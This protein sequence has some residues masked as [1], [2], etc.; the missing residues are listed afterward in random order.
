MAIDMT[1]WSPVMRRILFNGSTVSPLPGRI[2]P[3]DGGAGRDRGAA[4]ATAAGLGAG[5]GAATT[6]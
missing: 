1:M 3:L 5:L 6:G 4:G 2:G